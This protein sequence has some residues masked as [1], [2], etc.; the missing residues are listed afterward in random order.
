MGANDAREMLEAAK[1][2]NAI[3]E[4]ALRAA[5]VAEKAVRALHQ[6]EQF[7][8]C[9]EDGQRFPCST[10]R[11]MDYAS[12]QV[13]HESDRLPKFIEPLVLT[14]VLETR[15]PPAAAEWLLRWFAASPARRADLEAEILHDHESRPGVTG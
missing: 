14:A 1:D 13:Q 2:D 5:W 6:Q 9:V 11:V 8:D 7:G 10:I 15:T 3:L 12:T 4:R